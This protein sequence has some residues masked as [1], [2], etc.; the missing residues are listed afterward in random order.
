[1][2][3]Q[4]IAWD[5]PVFSEKYGYAGTID[6]VCTIDGKTYIVDFKTSKQ[7]WPE[8]ELQVSAYKKPIE[9]A[10]SSSTA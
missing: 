7:V 3:P 8:Y 9:L 2:K 1:M 5:V 4:S 6:Y 10:E